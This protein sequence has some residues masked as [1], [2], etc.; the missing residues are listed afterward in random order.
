MMSKH[1]EKVKNYY[2]HN[3]WSEQMVRN[4]I[5]KWITEDECEM[6]LRSKEVR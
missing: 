6:I 1:Y 2:L 5:G 3:I 4:A